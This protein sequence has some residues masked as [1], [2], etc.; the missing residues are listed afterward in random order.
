MET[1]YDGTTEQA[2]A[3]GRRLKNDLSEGVGP[4]PYGSTRKTS[5][6]RLTTMFAIARG[7]RLALP[8]WSAPSWGF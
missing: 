5:P 3:A 7:K 4:R 2:R 8:L 1:T 6:A